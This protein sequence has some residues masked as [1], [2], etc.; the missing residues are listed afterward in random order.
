ME[1]PANTPVS[2]PAPV[3][4]ALMELQLPG[5]PSDRELFKVY[6]RV[7]RLLPYTMELQRMDAA[8]G[9]GRQLKAEARHALVER[10]SI[11]DTRRDRTKSN[12]WTNPL[13]S[14][15][16]HALTVVKTVIDSE[17]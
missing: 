5:L 7:G 12:E 2:V 9:A 10:G 8:D 15:L 11:R 14:S 17:S 3:R 4:A 16:T 6:Q 13:L 1:A